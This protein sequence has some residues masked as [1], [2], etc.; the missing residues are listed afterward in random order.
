MKFGLM[1]VKTLS[2]LVFHRNTI[3]RSIPKVKYFM[4]SCS[5]NYAIRGEK[6]KSTK[7]LKSNVVNYCNRISPLKKL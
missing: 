5:F 2:F 4:L 1:L 7:E 6:H 3:A